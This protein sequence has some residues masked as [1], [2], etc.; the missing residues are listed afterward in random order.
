MKRTDLPFLVGALLLTPLSVVG[1]G[2]SPTANATTN[3]GVNLSRVVQ[4]ATTPVG[5]GFIRHY[6]PDSGYDAN[7]QF[8]CQGDPSDWSMGIFEGQ[9]SMTIPCLDVD[10]VTVY[11]GAEIWCK[12]GMAG[13]Y[14]W[15]KKFDATGKH[16]I[17]NSWEDGLGCTQ[18]KD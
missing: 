8:H 18:R 4:Q 12:Y 16:P 2:L 17:S 13:A 1:G 3:T 5:G 7:I 11:K 6:Y 10:S 14:V 15:R 9:D